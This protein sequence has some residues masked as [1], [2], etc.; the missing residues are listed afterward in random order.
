M[1][2]FIFPS[3]LWA[4]HCASYM[5]KYNIC[6]YILHSYN[7]VNKENVLK[8]IITFTVFIEKNLHINGPLQLKLVLYMSNYLG[9]AYYCPLI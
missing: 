1:R 4:K 5:A 2:I 9:H 6:Y 3:K 8:K 7:K